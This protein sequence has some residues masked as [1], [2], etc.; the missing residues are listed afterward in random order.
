[1]PLL[2]EAEALI[3]TVPE[4][5]APETGEVI[6]TVGRVELVLFTVI[7]TAAL[8]A[9]LFDVSVAIAVSV[10]VPFARVV[11]FKDFE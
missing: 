2:A 7:E 10:C 6:E 11:V 5:T 1:M 9:L 3:V 4:T 8:V